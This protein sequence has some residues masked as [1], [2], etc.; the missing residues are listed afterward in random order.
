[1]EKNDE[2]TKTSSLHTPSYR[3]KA[4]APVSGGYGLDFGGTA[5]GRRGMKFLSGEAKAGALLRH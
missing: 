3:R 5:A 4:G 2:N 1:M